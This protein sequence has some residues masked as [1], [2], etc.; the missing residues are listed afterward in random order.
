MD[1]APP[2]HNS[3]LPKKGLRGSSSFK[4]PRYTMRVAKAIV[5]HR[6]GNEEVLMI[7]AHD[8]PHETREETFVKICGGVFENVP[9]SGRNRRR[10]WCSPSS[11]QFPLP[12]SAFVINTM[13]CQRNQKKPQT[14][15]DAIASHTKQLSTPNVEID[16]P[17]EI[18]LQPPDQRP[19]ICLV[20][21]LE[22]SGATTRGNT[23]SK[24]PKSG[25]AHATANSSGRA[26]GHLSRPTLPSSLS[27]NPLGAGENDDDD[28]DE[29]QKKPAANSHEESDVSSDNS[30]KRRRRCMIR[31]GKRAPTNTSPGD[32]N[33]RK[34]DPEISDAQEGRDRWYLG[35]PSPFTCNEINDVDARFLRDGDGRSLDEGDGRSLGEGDGR[36]LREGDGR[37]LREGDGRSLRDNDERS[38]CDG[39]GRSLRD[40]DERSLCDGDGRSL[41][42]G[43]GRYSLL[44]DGEIDCNCVSS[45]NASTS[46]IIPI[47]PP[48]A[49]VRGRSKSNVAETSKKE[50]E[51]PRR[52]ST[53]DT[54]MRYGHPRVGTKFPNMAI[55]GF[56]RACGMPTTAQLH[57]SAGKRYTF[58]DDNGKK[59]LM[60]PLPIP[61]NISERSNSTPRHA[62]FPGPSR[63]QL[64]AD[65]ARG[66]EVIAIQP[67]NAAREESEGRPGWRK[68]GLVQAHVITGEKTRHPRW[69]ASLRPLKLQR[70][71]CTKES[72]Y[73]NCA[74]STDSSITNDS[75]IRKDESP[76]EYGLMLENSVTTSS[77]QQAA[78]VPTVEDSATTSSAQQAAGV[79]TVEDSVTTYSAQNAAG[80]DSTTASRAQKAAGEDSTTTSR[81]QKAAGE[82]S[83]TTS[84]AQQAAGVPTVENSAMISSVQQAASLPTVKEHA[85]TQSA[86]Q[87]VDVPMAEQ[88]A[89]LQSA[90]QPA[91]ST[92]TTALVHRTRSHGASPPT[93]LDRGVRATDSTQS[94]A[95]TLPCAPTNGDFIEPNVEYRQDSARSGS[96]TSC[97]ACG[98][99]FFECLFCG[100]FRKPKSPQQDLLAPPTP[101]VLPEPAIPLS[102]L[103]QTALPQT[104]DSN[105]VGA[106][107]IGGTEWILIDGNVYSLGSRTV[108]ATPQSGTRA[109]SVATLELAQIEDPPSPRA[110][111]PRDHEA[112]GE[113]GGR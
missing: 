77:A 29:D 7:D 54:F 73:G 103:N 15:D 112:S 1:S 111:V 48:Q 23:S 98:C 56:G 36:S 66:R 12:E 19:K 90:H 108:N 58:L 47:D 76:L 27:R 42:N 110:K 28:G 75:I 16:A 60:N 101:L 82:D 67:S 34:L 11:T 95:N 105:V 51:R 94:R 86:Q 81:A 59:V 79:P 55:E 44:A 46:D 20:S 18:I 72:G 84:S 31:N 70:S 4:A 32:Y 69:V 24:S 37:S 113:N 100:S 50:P 62:S 74:D 68:T 104:A 80:E 3:L 87:S 10:T 41:R 93:P 71:G 17:S 85:M 92:S 109:T 35:Y 22:N 106:P 30:E 91:E 6:D 64:L 14:S 61:S 45:R 5:K 97:V 38:L 40:N 99:S 65:S 63:K 53:V 13:T 26:G 49:T 78:G 8:L 21:K 9:R 96:A 102:P 25:K 39:N 89:I 107:S 83:E 43:D 52:N 88:T 2:S 57:T 33:S